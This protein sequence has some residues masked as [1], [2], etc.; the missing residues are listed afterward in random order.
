MSQII[1]K[2][3]VCGGDHSIFHCENETAQSSTKAAK[4]VLMVAEEDI[5][6]VGSPLTA[7]R[8]F[9]PRQKQEPAS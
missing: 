5:F 1:L 6:D 9:Y 7:L 4:K 2:C 3:T 8:H